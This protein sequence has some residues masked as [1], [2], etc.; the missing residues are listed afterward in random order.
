MALERRHVDVCV[1]YLEFGAELPAAVGLSDPW[2][3]KNAAT[4][5]TILHHALCKKEV[6]PK[7]IATIIKARPAL[8]GTVNNAN[9]MPV[10]LAV[11]T[12]LSLDIILML[13]DAHPLSFS[14]DSSRNDV[15]IYSSINCVC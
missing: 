13:L 6:K 3:H 9:E 8:L 5:N 10:H 11:G 15:R 7:C 14:E 12:G 2:T 4:G 1:L